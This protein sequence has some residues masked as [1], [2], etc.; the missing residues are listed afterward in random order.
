[1]HT[2]LAYGL[3]ALV[4]QQPASVEARII[5]YLRDNL[6][7][8]QGIDISDLVNDVFTSTEEREA[9]SRLYNS[10]FKVPA[11]LA[12]FQGRTG[13]IPSL[14]EISEQFSLTDV[15]GATNCLS[16]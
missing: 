13:E 11:F 6:Q 4:L 10:F 5:N 15:P 1:M 2:W 16:M 14:Q 8:G 12:Q 9:L 7:P 3:M